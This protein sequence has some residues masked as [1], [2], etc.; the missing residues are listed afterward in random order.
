M[1]EKVVQNYY[2]CPTEAKTSEKSDYLSHCPKKFRKITLF[3][4]LKEKVS[5]NQFICPNEGKS[6]PQLLDLSQ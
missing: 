3:V 2:F 5:K 6:Y 1:K 4:R